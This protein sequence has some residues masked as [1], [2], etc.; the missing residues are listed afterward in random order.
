MESNTMIDVSCILINYNSSHYTIP[1]VKSIIENT[2]NT[3][4]YEI[5][6]V[7]NASTLEDYKILE[8]ELSIFDT[9]LVKLIR[10]HMNIGFGGGNMLGVKKAN[11]PTY[12]AFINN[13]TLMRSINTLLELKSFMELT[14]SAGIESRQMLE[15]GK[16][17]RVTIDHFSSPQREILRRPILEALFPSTYL[18]RKKR[19]RKP[20][21]VHYVQGAF[22][23]CDA[24]YFNKIG[25]FDTNL[26]LY[27][28]ESDVSRQ[29]LKEY[30]KKTYIIPHLEYIHYKGGSTKKGIDLKIEQK[31][32]LLY[33]I[34][35]HYGWFSKTV[36]IVHF[37]IR[38]FFTALIKPKYWPLFYI[39]LLGAPMAKSLK[40]QQKN[41]NES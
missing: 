37:G 10:S 38:Y 2:E 13:D 12:Y 33:Y 23:F 31:L 25:G 36:L 19:F 3:I 4:V 28:E 5:I 8:K 41:Y 26:F 14:E 9:S 24:E 40:H 22:M 1:C 18:N 15:E 39:F 27:Y 17:F 35:K 7:D 16:K 20:T 29:L 32:S 21:A 11:K 34:E 30:N 6:V